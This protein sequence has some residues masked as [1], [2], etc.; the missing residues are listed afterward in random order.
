MVLDAKYRPI[1]PVRCARTS[2]TPMRTAYCM[3]P[4]AHREKQDVSEKL[5]LELHSTT[6]LVHAIVQSC[7]IIGRRA[8]M[9]YCCFF[10]TTLDGVCLCWLHV[11]LQHSAITCIKLAL[12]PFY[13]TADAC[14]S[15]VTATTAYL[16]CCV[17]PV[18]QVY[19][20]CVH[21]GKQGQHVS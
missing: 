9:K 17:A 2:I 18:L 3:T 15:C 7:M 20:Q 5:G 8:A 14:W 19:L 11:A 4:A 12:Q 6:R 16:C 13:T 10:D 21:P 1:V